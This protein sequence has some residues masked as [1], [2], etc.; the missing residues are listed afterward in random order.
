MK[1]VD[2]AP[3]RFAKGPDVAIILAGLVTA[4]TFSAWPDL[5]VGIGI[6]F[7]NLDAA[8]EVYISARRERAGA[9]P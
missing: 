5:I 2:F 7:M 3:C 4:Y 9:V 6:F 8:R 1:C